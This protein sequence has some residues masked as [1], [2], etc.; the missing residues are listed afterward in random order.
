MENSKDECIRGEDKDASFFNL[1]PG[2]PRSNLRDEN[3]RS[4]NN[5]IEVF[6]DQIPEI[7]P[8]PKNEHEA[9]IFSTSEAK[10]TG[11]VPLASLTAPALQAPPRSAKK[12]KHKRQWLHEHVESPRKEHMVK[13][14][15]S[16]EELHRRRGLTLFQFFWEQGMTCGRSYSALIVRFPSLSESD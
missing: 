13:R 4:D 6:Y 9:A 8:S 3:S 10:V 11:L 16:L 1:N 15:V 14:V 12:P 2:G 5:K 7:A